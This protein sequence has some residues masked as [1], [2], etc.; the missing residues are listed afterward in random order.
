MTGDS[1]MNKVSEISIIVPL[2]N[3]VNEVCRAIDSIFAQ[4]I[5]GFELIVVDGGSTDGSLDVIKKYDGDSRLHLLH[6]KSKGLPAGRNEAIASAKYDLIVFLDAD[7]EWHPT[8]LEKI[9]NLREK[10]PDAGLYATAFETSYGDYITEPRLVD[11][12]KA[13]WDG[14]M[15]SYFRTSALAFIYPFMPCCVAIPKTTFEKVGLFNPNLRTGEDAEMWGRIALE[16]PI[17]YTSSVGAT[18]YAVA[19]NKMTDNPNVMDRHPFLEYLDKYPQ[20]KLKKHPDYENILLY[21]QK[22][23]IAIALNNLYAK[24]PKQARKNLKNVTDK[25]FAKYKYVLLALSYLPIPIMGRIL[26]IAN[27]LGRK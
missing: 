12:P 25:R 20:D 24:A 1:I 10:Y 17:A 18:Y 6:Q 3:K 5:Q 26:P 14:I 4:T 15:P 9:L 13:P 27:K 21:I 7:D 8:F 2:Y 11:V 19:N 22:E 16:L 23:E